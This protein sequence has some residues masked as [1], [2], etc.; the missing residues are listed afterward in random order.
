MLARLL[1]QIGGIVMR[2]HAQALGDPCHGRRCLPAQA[3][4]R[5][6]RTVRRLRAKGTAFQFQ[7]TE[8][9]RSVLIPV[10]LFACDQPI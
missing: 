10:R 2:T 8:T 3:H 9:I 5:F 1:E 7:Q 4:R 6:A